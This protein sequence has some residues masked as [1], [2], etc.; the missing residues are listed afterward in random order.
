MKSFWQIRSCVENSLCWGL[1]IGQG[2]ATLWMWTRFRLH[3]QCECH[4]NQSNRHGY[5]EHFS[6]DLTDQ[7][8]RS[9]V[10]NCVIWHAY[11]A[12][13]K[14]TI[15]RMCVCNDVH[16]HMVVIALAVCCLQ[17]WRIILYC[18]AVYFVNCTVWWWLHPGLSLAMLP[19]KP[20]LLETGTCTY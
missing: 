18:M 16:M 9:K 13:Y 7:R 1:A 19:S 2:P 8:G 14:D 5:M 20:G 11:I 4:Q 10:W 6:V 15:L 12:T 3:T 17:H